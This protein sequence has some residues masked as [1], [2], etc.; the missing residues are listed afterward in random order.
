MECVLGECTLEILGLA[1]CSCSMNLEQLTFGIFRA[2]AYREYSQV[3]GMRRQ[4]RLAHTWKQAY[5]RVQESLF[6]LIHLEI[7][8]SGRL[9]VAPNSLQS[10]LSILLRQES[11]SER[12]IR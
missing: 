11:C 8:D 9:L 10:D 12:G 2:T 6:H 7:L 3:Y 1:N 5:I 4:V